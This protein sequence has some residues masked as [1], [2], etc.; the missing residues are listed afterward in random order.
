MPGALLIDVDS[1]I[2]NLALMHISTW[3]K[4]LG[5]QT[6]F[7]IEDPDE[8]WASCIFHKNKH[9]LDGLKAFYPDAK[10]DIGGGGVDLHKNL[11][12]EVDLL[13]PDYSIYP[14]CDYDVG[15]T[16]RGCNRRC[17]FCVVPKKEGRFHIHQHPS[18]F[19][20]P[21]HKSVML[22][23]NNI[24]FDKDWFFTVTDWI[25]ENKLKVDFN[26]GLDIRL[27]DTQIARRISELKPMKRWHFA[28]DSLDYQD[29]VI[30]G[31]R[32]LKDAG[33]DLHHRSNW[34]VYM[35]SDED[36]ESARERCRILREMDALPYIMVNRD[37]P[38]T[39][40]MTNL[41]RWT[42][43][44]IFFTTDYEEYARSYRARMTDSTVIQRQ[45]TLDCLETYSKPLKGVDIE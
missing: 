43:P 7:R 16:T 32:M 17:H 24:L 4:S 14:N 20:D 41:K 27:M 2:P 8:I 36:W 5:I 23:D 22:M 19:H 1:V 37:A 11:P 3:R 39:Q 34:Y 35:D 15:F 10:I 28:F 44:H 31:I 29:D 12:S 18:E 21:S 9:K 13:M 38:R 26:Q 42:R 30:D 6:G 33:L 40:R 25:L 45:A